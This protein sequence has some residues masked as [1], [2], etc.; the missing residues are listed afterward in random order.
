MHVPPDGPNEIEE[1]SDGDTV[2]RFERAFLTSN[3]TCIWGRGCQG[4]LPQR[5]EQLG[6]GCCSVGAEIDGDDEARLVAASTAALQPE[7]FQFHAQALAGGVFSD[8]TCSNTR[9]VDGACIFLNRPGFAGGE[10]CALHIAAVAA[11]ESPI[12]WKPSVCWQLPIRVD[13]EMRDDGIELAEVRGWRR[14]DWGADGDT[15]A[16]CCTEEPEAFVGDRMVIDSLAEELEAIVGVAV[17]VEL[18]RRLTGA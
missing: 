13:W 15:M 6:Q 12:D 18:R 3:W 5:A 16:W 8:D 9:V 2:W 14:A 17:V 4:I 11:D 10:G 7:R 1:I